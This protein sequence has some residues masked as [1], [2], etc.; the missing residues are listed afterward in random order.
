M[1]FME[2]GEW[3]VGFTTIFTGGHVGFTIRIF[4]FTI[5]VVENTVRSRKNTIPLSPFTVQRIKNT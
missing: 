2:R 1:H 4:N 5:R 3:E